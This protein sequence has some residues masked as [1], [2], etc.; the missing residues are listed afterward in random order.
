MS[1]NAS[2]LAFVVSLLLPKLLVA[3]EP[4]AASTL[5][6]TNLGDSGAPGQLRTL[7]N[8]AALGDTIVIP[9]GTITLTGTVG[10]NAN[11]GGEPRPASSGFRAGGNAHDTGVTSKHQASRHLIRRLLGLRPA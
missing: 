7:M 11:V 6:V 8:L 2:R 3:P 10:E 1:S 9:A 4:L 5:T